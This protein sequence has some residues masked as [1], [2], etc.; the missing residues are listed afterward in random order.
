MG[1]RGALDSWG[2]EKEGHWTPGG[3]IEGYW[4]INVE[5]FDWS[6]NRLVTWI[7]NLPETILRLCAGDLFGYVYVG[8]T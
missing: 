1:E 4:T 3:W 5:D 7:M 2:K 8:G 6:Q